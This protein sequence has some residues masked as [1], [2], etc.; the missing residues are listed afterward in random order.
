MENLVVVLAALTYTKAILQA[1]DFVHRNDHY[2]KL[3]NI[4]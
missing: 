1:F 2:C 3:Q 4:A